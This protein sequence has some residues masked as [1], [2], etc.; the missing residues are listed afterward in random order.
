MARYL[1]VEEVIEDVGFC[2]GTVMDAIKSGELEAYKIRER[3][4]IPKDAVDDWICGS[5]AEEDD[6]LHDEDK[7]LDTEYQLDDEEPEE[8]KLD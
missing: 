2:R 7:D 6:E 1:S 5:E 4:R 3:W 8:E